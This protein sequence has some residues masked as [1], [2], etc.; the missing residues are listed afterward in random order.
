[1]PENPSKVFKKKLLLNPKKENKP[2]KKLNNFNSITNVIIR[3]IN[4]IKPCKKYPKNFF[5]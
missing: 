2:A 3:G 5:I 4:K 1:V